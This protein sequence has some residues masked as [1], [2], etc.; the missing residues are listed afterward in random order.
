MHP[1][2]IVLYHKGFLFRIWIILDLLSAYSSIV[3]VSIGSDG[4]CHRFLLSEDKCS[5]PTCESCRGIRSG[6]STG[7]ICK[8]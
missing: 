8:E 1:N 3:V 4:K 5:N 7:N 2:N 6:E